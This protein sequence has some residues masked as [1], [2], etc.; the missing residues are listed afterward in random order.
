MS[1]ALTHP[2]DIVTEREDSVLHII[3]NRPDVLNAVTA[4]HLRR[5]TREYLRAWR[6][7]SIGAVLLS[8][9]GRAFCA[10]HDLTGPD[11]GAVGAGAWN[12]LFEVMEEIPKPTIAAVNGVAV[13]GGLHLGLSC[14]L[15]LC[16]DEATI[17]ESFVWIGACPDT[18]GHLY[19]QRSIGHQRAAELLMMGRKIQARE[20]ADA[21]LFMASLPTQE[22]LLDEAWRV[23]R[24]LARGPRL[25]YAVTRRGLEYARLHSRREVLDWE[26]EE[27][28][29]MTR[30]QDMREGVAAFLDKREPRF[31][32]E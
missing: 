17:G 25:S 9:R 12:R 23:A 14:D 30:T 21:G 4:S 6:D 10:G 16:A 26:A 20:A 31:R 5:L 11:L 13:G 18:G 2:E 15:V 32:G 28:E 27:E 7:D 22:A 8:G 19:L 29:A 1:V 24:H 3:L